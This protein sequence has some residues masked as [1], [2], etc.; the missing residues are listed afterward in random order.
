MTITRFLGLSFFFIFLSGCSN[1]IAGFGKDMQQM[2]T[3]ISNA[4]K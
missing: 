4:A 3:A 1:T 2:G